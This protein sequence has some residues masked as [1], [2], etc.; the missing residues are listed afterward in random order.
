[1]TRDR[2]LAGRELHEPIPS[3]VHQRRDKVVTARANHRTPMR[4]ASS[5]ELQRARHVAEIGVRTTRQML[6]QVRARAL[7]VFR[8][9]RGKNHERDGVA[10]RRGTSAWRLLK[11][12]VRVGPAYPKRAYSGPPRL[13]PG[14][15]RY[16][17]VIHVERA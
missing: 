8:G 14:R 4:E 15:P 13:E 17:A 7:K 6:R 10:M 16:Q 5:S 2:S 12:D 11:H 9:A 1:M 3:L